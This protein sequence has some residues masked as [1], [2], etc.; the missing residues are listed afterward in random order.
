MRNIINSRNK[1]IVEAENKTKRTCIC[2][3]K[4]NCPFND[5]C[6][7]KDVYKE[8]VRDKKCIG[9]TELLSKQGGN[10]RSTVSLRKYKQQH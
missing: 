9:S 7:L 2:R 3:N 10:R 4:T 6:L 5:E 8:E 1:K